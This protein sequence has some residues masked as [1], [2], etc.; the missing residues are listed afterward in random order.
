AKGAA[1][2]AQGGTT[3][4]ASAQGGTT[5]AQAAATASAGKA[6]GGCAAPTGAQGAGDATASAQGCSS[7][8][9]QGA[10]TSPPPTSPPPP[11]P[12]PPRHHLR[13]RGTRISPIQRRS[14]RSKHEPPTIQDGRGFFCA[15]VL[16]TSARAPQP[17]ADL[18][19]Q[20]VGDLVGVVPAGQPD[21][22]FT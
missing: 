7:T 17:V 2:S 6:E 10:G 3:T 9:S 18:A 15:I 13:P 8:T 1:T 5:T 14:L 11:P 16:P 4:S 21:E 12:P 19:E 22:Q 20:L